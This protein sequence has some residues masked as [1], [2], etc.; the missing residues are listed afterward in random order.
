M[1]GTPKGLPL[2]DKMKK[3]LVLSLGWFTLS[4]AEKL[5]EP[6]ENLIPEEKMVEIL[7]D[8]TILNAAKTSFPNVL[9]ENDFGIMEFLYNK[10]KIDSVQFTESDRY[11]ASLPVQ[12]QSIYEQVEGKLEKRK[13]ILEETHREEKDSVA[14]AQR[15]KKVPKAK[16]K[17]DQNG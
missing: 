5:I 17:K 1:G 3:V 12:Y 6:P 7:H 15:L 9:N 10:H 14:K 8:L 16:S 11:Y 2:T 13:K 4:C